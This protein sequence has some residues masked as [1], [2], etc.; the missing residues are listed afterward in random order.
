MIETL[1]K[2]Y[3]D[4]LLIKQVHP[5]K[6][7]TIWNYSRKVQYERLWDDVTTMC[8]GIVTNSKGEIVSRSFP[9]FFNYEELKP[10]EIP[11]EPF[12]VTEEM[13]G[14]LGLL[15][16]YEDEWIFASRGSFTSVYA[17]KGRQL[18]EK[19]DYKKLTRD[20]TYIFEIIFKEGRI[21][22][23]YDYE[24]LILIGCINIPFGYEIDI[25]DECFENRAGF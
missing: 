15:F 14:Q 16:W 11:N 5:T 3:N 24:D 19:Y 21:V 9:K 2:Y 1:E 8:R 10:T 20:N 17:E 25:H 6:N 4:G 13:D 12:D 23:K 7:L 22:C 18:L